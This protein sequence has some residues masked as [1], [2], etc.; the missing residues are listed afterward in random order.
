M[1][2]TKQTSMRML[3]GFSAF[4]L[5]LSLGACNHNNVKE[6]ND[7]NRSGVYLT[8]INLEGAVSA[9]IVIDE[10]A[11]KAIEA[12]RS[13]RLQEATTEFNISLNKNFNSSSLQ[14]LNGINYHLRAIGGDNGLFD[15]A[16]QGYLAAIRF[17]KSNWTARYYLGMFYM[18]TK[19]YM[20]A[21]RQFGAYVVNNDSDPEAL[22]YLATASY[23]SADPVTAHAAA[24]RL[25]ELTETLASPPIEPSAMLRLLAM[26]KA[27]VNKPDE[28]SNLIDE[29]MAKGGEVDHAVMLRKRLD[30]WQHVYAHQ[31]VDTKL[32]DSA[33]EE[34]EQAMAAADA[35]TSNESEADDAAMDESDE[36]SGMD[37]MDESDEMS[38]MEEESDDMITEEDESENESNDGEFVE[39]QMVA[40]DVVIIRSEE[41]VTE[42]KGIN[43]LDGLLLQFGSIANGLDAFS[44]GQ[45]RLKDILD[46]TQST[47]TKA[48]TKLIT[49][50][51]V[52]YTL[53]ILNEQGGRSEV[54][55]RPTLVSR[56][57]QTSE[58]FSGVEISAA[59]VSGGAGDSV[60][61]EKEVGLKLAITPEMGPEDV[62][63]LHVIAERTFLTQPSSSVVFEFRLDTTKTLVDANVAMKFGQTLILSGL[64]ERITE[65]NLDG[66][67][68][69]KDTP[70]L[71]RFFSEENIQSQKRSVI[72]LLTPRPASYL[73]SNPGT[74]LT[75]IGD[76]NNRPAID[77]LSDR[78]ESWFK[79]MS[80]TQAILDRIS[81]G[82]LYKYFQSRDLPIDVWYK[83]DSHSLRMREIIKQLQI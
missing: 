76:L 36:M 6:P 80:N 47:S 81:T 22:Y 82:N 64:D 37:E 4:C 59:A 30:D 75:T 7:I 26:T 34:M 25:W 55:A 16:E 21:Q 41:T 1:L 23:Y 78:Y 11:K 28:A 79:P 35:L 45:A 17:D 70:F 77:Q 66:V 46:P 27:A 61:I 53:N 49:V 51:A 19:R 83:S 67:P 68:V 12:M 38:G 2:I 73:Y 10:H 72:I 58:F 29:Y 15:M 14:L 42:A 24:M 52:S 39:S 48:I 60:S 3:M 50:P 54:L 56:A 8:S 13:G 57:G 20:D 74:G 32:E 43:L 69:L 63:F 71:K 62:V 18:D 33:E 40:V 9:D 44:S 65:S 5:V 31:E